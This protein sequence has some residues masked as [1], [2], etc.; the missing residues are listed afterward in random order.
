MAGPASKS[1]RVHR[2]RVRGRKDEPVRDHYA[3]HPDGVTTRVRFVPASPEATARALREPTWPRRFKALRKANG[4]TMVQLAEGFRTTHQMI[5]RVEH[6]RIG[7]SHLVGLLATLVGVDERHIMGGRK[8]FTSVPARGPHAERLIEWRAINGLSRRRAAD[9]MGLP[10]TYE[11]IRRIER[12]GGMR[13]DVYQALE[14]HLHG[15]RA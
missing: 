4:I 1:I 14:S 13:Q 7:R 11:I 2:R 10:I 6:G 9:A 3:Y 5:L 15:G 12:G 8:P